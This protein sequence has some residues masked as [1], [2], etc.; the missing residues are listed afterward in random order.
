M[1]RNTKLN[2]M[3]AESRPSEDSCPLGFGFGFRVRV[4][5]GFPDMTPIMENQIENKMDIAQGVLE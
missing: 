1:S 3:E 2:H 4:Y 5:G